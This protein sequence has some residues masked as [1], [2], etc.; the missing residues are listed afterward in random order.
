VSRRALFHVQHLLGIGHA[1]RIAAVARATAARGLEVTVLSGGGPLGLD[2]GDARVIQLPAARAPDGN[3]KSLVDAQDRPLDAAFHE[4][5]RDLVLAAFRSVRPHVLL[6]ESY[7]FGRRAFRW[8]L[9]A[10]IAEAKAETSPV[11]VL[12]SIRDIL[13]AKTDPK[14]VQEIVRR[15][16]A[17]I[18]A[19]LV[20][21]DP[22]LAPLEASFPAAVSFSDKVIY[23][24]Y[25]T[26]INQANASAE[27]EFPSGPTNG[28][29]L[30]SA[31]GGA[32]GAPLLR[33]A[34]AARPQTSLAQHPWRLIAGPNLPQAEF[35]ILAKGLPHGV[36][37]ERFRSD[38]RH[39]LRHCHLSLSQAGYNTILDILQAGVRAVV[40]PFATGG[41]T[42]QAL[43]ARILAERGLI[44]VADPDSLSGPTLAAAIERA[45]AGPPPA[46]VSLA[47]D[48]ARQAAERIA[49][50]AAGA[51]LR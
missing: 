9:D 7:P 2:W 25:V 10:L 31:G 33:A 20:H 16:Q 43:R 51:G 1:M 22:N 39:R 5:R 50:F 41:E 45:L 36:T 49:V 46:S 15:V 35:E 3:F 38:F 11:P 30:V 8:E 42:E 32:V 13:V 21:G 26:G 19:V 29:I 14:R 47:L 34:L 40:V 27:A 28:E 18:A 23:T 37:L 4:R 24:G 12:V 17:D 44:Y 48:G 6:V